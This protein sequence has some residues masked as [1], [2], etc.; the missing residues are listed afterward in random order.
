[1]L[2]LNF[3]GFKWFDA[4]VCQQLFVFRS[5]MNLFASDN[6]LLSI[7]G[8]SEFLKNSRVYSSDFSY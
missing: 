6:A 1:M 8:F 4:G 2:V 7:I 5:E 3:Q